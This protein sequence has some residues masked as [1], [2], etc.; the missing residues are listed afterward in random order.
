MLVGLFH[1]KSTNTSPLVKFVVFQLRCTS[2]ARAPERLLGA[3]VLRY[4]FVMA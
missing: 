1:S 3:V 2:I 4:T